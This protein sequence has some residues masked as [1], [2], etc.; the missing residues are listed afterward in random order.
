V[1]FNISGQ[2][3]IGDDYFVDV[4]DDGLPDL[5][6]QGQV[7][8]N[9]LVIDPATGLKTPQFST[10]STGTAV[11]VDDATLNERQVQSVKDLEAQQRAQSPLQDTVRRWI[12]PFSGTVAVTGQ[13]KLTP[14]PSADGSAYAGDGVRV[15]VDLG[16]PSAACI[17]NELWAA[18][19]TTP[20]QTVTPTGVGA[21][22]ITRGQALYFRL[23]S[24]D[25]GHAARLLR[26]PPPGPVLSDPARRVATAPG[27]A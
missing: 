21:V 15:S 16:C 14:A 24:V 3:T 10:S 8:F 25:D 18:P 17:A 6:H 26:K 2:V 7:Y 20:G 23:Q 1:Q 13:V 27:P 9:H 19:L 5:V 11:P 22:S 4:N 12:A